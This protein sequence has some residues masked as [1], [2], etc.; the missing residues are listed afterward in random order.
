MN[1]T[2]AN[3][4]AQTDG[5]TSTTNGNISPTAQTTNGNASTTDGNTSPTATMN[6]TSANGTAQ[7]DGNTSTTNGNISPTVQTTVGNASTTA[8]MNIT[9]A[10]ATV[11]PGCSALPVL[12]CP[13]HNNSCFR[14]G[15]F[16][17]EYCM[18]ARDC[19][20]DF[21]LTCAQFLNSTNSS[22]TSPPPTATTVN[23]TVTSN[24]FNTSTSTSPDF[25]PVTLHLKVSLLARDRENKDR[26]SEA[27][28]NYLS[29]ILLQ[30]SCENCMT[31]KKIKFN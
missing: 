6:I 16:C 31:I 9:S 2:S 8:Q 20:S 24:R 4:T 28:S 14:V 10:N 11:G 30:Q 25:Q 26:I 27:L 12:C 29:S 7:T 3:G 5:N 21:G 18:I 23:G 17:D 13:G 22:T 15:C 1:I 19:C